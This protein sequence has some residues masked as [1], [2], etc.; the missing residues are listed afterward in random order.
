MKVGSFPVNRITFN[1]EVIMYKKQLAFQKFVCLLAIFGGA[2]VFVYSLGIMTDLYDCLYSTMMN[3]NNLSQ[4]TVEGSIVYYDMQ[5]FNRMFLYSGIAMILIN[6]LLFLTNTNTRRKYYVGNYVATAL[7]VV[8]DLA[9][10]VW[11]HF[12]IEKYKA[13]FLQIDFEALKA[14]SELWKT[15]YTESTFWFDLHYGV[16]AFVL[17]SAALLIINLIWKVI[18]MNSEKR[19][20]EK[21]KGAAA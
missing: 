7:N 11:A 19:L 2:A 6:C 21:G 16:F 4:T 9:I 20:I 14:H 8:A 17:F 3:P 10:A 5:G 13:Q 12:E 15:A 18:L 1:G